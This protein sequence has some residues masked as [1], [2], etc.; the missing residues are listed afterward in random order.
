MQVEQ[1]ARIWKISRSEPTVQVTVVPTHRS[2]LGSAQKASN[3]RAFFQMNL[4]SCPR[5]VR[6]QC[7]STLI[8][9]IMGYRYAVWNSHAQK[10]KGCLEKVRHCARFTYQDFSRESSITRMTNTL[11]WEPLV[12]RRAKTRVTMLYRINLVPLPF[13]AYLRPLHGHH[14]SQP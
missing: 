12:E 5:S 6:A 1:V 7:H 10:N 4:R 13:A 9:P 3:T 8:R 2:Q 14:N 11:W